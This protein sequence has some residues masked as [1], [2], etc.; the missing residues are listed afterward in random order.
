MLCIDLVTYGRSEMN[1]H[2]DTV[3]GVPAAPLRP[4]IDVVS[5][6]LPS[7]QM[8]MFYRN[9]DAFVLPT[10]GEGMRVERI[11]VTHIEARIFKF[12]LAPVIQD[13]PL[14]FN[15][16]IGLRGRMGVANS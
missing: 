1:D 16:F 10:H 8:P 15:W 2:L 13:H 6:H 9:C 11:D 14:I 12:I 3:E 4:P 5:E 7:W